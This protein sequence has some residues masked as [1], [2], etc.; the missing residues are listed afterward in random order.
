MLLGLCFLKQ[1]VI[2]PLFIFYGGFP[3]LPFLPFSLNLKV[4]GAPT[5]K[6][7][8]SLTDILV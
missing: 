8:M 2:F 4:S 5:R 1:C 7:K 3:K 6:L